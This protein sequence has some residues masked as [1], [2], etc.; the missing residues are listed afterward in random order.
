MSLNFNFHAVTIF[1]A[2]SYF[3]TGIDALFS[4][5]LNKKL[6]IGTV[7]NILLTV[8]MVKFIKFFSRRSQ[9]EHFSKLLISSFVTFSLLFLIDHMINV[10]SVKSLNF[11]LLILLFTKLVNNHL[12]KYSE[13]KE[14]TF[15]SIFL[16]VL[17]MIIFSFIVNKID[18]S[19][20]MDYVTFFEKIS[21][22]KFSVIL[23][24]FL[25]LVS[26]VFLRGDSNPSDYFNQ[27]IVRMNNRLL[28]NVLI[29]CIAFY[30]VNF[31]YSVSGLLPEKIHGDY[32][33]M[34]SL[35]ITTL[36]SL[37]VYFVTSWVFVLKSFIKIENKNTMMLYGS[38]TLFLIVL[39]HN[40]YIK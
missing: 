2:L 18:S 11:I 39:E 36:V 23:L 10:Q 34:S 1:L 15:D 20:S 21:H 37:F 26:L 13:K 17:S 9:R 12:E 5:I 14:D 8:P 32:Q 25:Q 4:Q 3:A 40:G 30:Y 22:Y 29:F 7:L 16:M 27:T 28:I 19:R 38:I 35:I 6:K 24:A 33:L 31:L